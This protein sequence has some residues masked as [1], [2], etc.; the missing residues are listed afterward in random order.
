MPLT[1]TNQPHQF[2]TTHYYNMHH[3]PHTPSHTHQHAY[4]LSKHTHHKPPHAPIH[5]A[6]TSLIRHNTL[7]HASHSI[8]YTHQATLTNTYNHTTTHINHHATSKPSQSPPYKTTHLHN[9]YTQSTFTYLPQPP[10]H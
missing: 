3:T 2:S 8:H 5:N 1:T 9:I 4:T 10:T 6:T 7:L